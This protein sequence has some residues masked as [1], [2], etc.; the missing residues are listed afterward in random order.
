MASVASWKEGDK[1]PVKGKEGKNSLTR[2]VTQI[3]HGTI[4]FIA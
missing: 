4:E 2:R 1:A 3:I